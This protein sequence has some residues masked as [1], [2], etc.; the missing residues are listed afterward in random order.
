MERD[1][2]DRVLLSLEIQ[3]VATIDLTVTPQS[4]PPPGALARRA[5]SDDHVLELEAPAPPEGHD[6]VMLLSDESGALSWHFPRAASNAP[7]PA[8]PRGGSEPVTFCVPG[9]PVRHPATTTNRGIFARLGRKIL[10]LLVYPISDRLVGPRA[11]RF[12][13]TWEERNRPY[14][15]RTLTPENYTDPYASTLTTH[16]AAEWS[17]LA[18]GRLLLF[19][20]GTFSTIHGGFTGLDPSDIR[21]FSNAYG[22]RL[23]GFD[24]FTLSH[25]PARNVEELARRLPSD[26]TLHADIVCHGRGG[27]VSREV[28]ERGAKHRLEARLEI[29]R[30]VFVGVPNAGTALTNPEHITH[31]IDRM[32]TAINALPDTPLTSTL[33][34]IITAVKV[35]R[36]GGLQS[37]TGLA[38]MNPGSAWTTDASATTVPRAHY[39]GVAAD[40][41]PRGT[42]FERL[43]LKHIAAN[44]A[45]DRVFADERND[46]VVPTAGVAAAAGPG[47]PI[48]PGDV[49]MLDKASQVTHTTYFGSQMV[50]ERLRS[51]LTG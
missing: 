21:A 3:D 15:L 38:A 40:F 31:L 20:H 37:L 35:I 47:F 29:G 13:E 11:D 28:V 43:A 16:H 2:F 50:R 10:K 17:R 25:D 46:L 5:P 49:L 48:D 30:V 41:E 24:H 32:T 34:A 12:A 4:A 39:F 14:R 51:W 36:H 45:T 42:P 8:T 26:Q 9:A 18:S 23:L 19:V 27:L 44:R 7:E 22:G 6:V 1:A 33:E